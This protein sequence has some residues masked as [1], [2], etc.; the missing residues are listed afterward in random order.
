MAYIG[1]NFEKREEF[2]K[3][4]KALELAREEML[5]AVP[6][7]IPDDEW[8]EKTEHVW[9]QFDEEIAKLRLRC[10]ALEYPECRNAW[11]KNFVESFGICESKKVSSK[12]ADIFYR[13]TEQSHDNHY[14]VVNYRYVRVGKLFITFNPSIRYGGYVTIKQFD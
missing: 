11:F 3:A 6:E 14:T 7:N 4:I 9:S 1:R 12:Q 5:S 10:F 13:Y 8:E 2:N